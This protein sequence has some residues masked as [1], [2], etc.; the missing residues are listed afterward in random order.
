M[1][2]E[3]FFP[4]MPESMYSEILS[5][6]CFIIPRIEYAFLP[7]RLADVDVMGPALLLNSMQKRL[8]GILKP[9]LPVL[10]R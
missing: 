2:V 10:D 5:P 1:S 6:N 4:N 8:S 9:T 7:E 3:R